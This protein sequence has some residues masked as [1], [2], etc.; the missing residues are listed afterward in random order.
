MNLAFL[1]HRCGQLR[2]WEALSFDQ[3]MEML[4]EMSEIADAFAKS[5][6]KRSET[7]HVWEKPHSSDL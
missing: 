7:T 6:A 4:A 1:Q 3:K 2:E 5:R